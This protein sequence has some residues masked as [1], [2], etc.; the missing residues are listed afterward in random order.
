LKR[1]LKTPIEVEIMTEPKRYNEEFMEMLEKLNTI[2]IKKGEPF[3]ARAYQKAQETIMT[4]PNN[5]ISPNQLKG[6]PNIGSTIMDKLQEYVSTGTLRILESEKTNPINIL[7]DVYGIGPKKAQELV[8]S[9]ITT[10][11]ELR[12]RQNELLNDIQK[13]GLRYYEEIQERIPRSEIE[14]YGVVFKELFAKVSDPISKF[15]IVGSYRRGAQSSGDIDVIIT[16][17]TCIVYL[18]FVNELLKTGIIVELLSYGQSKTL[19]IAR[20]PGSNRIA[21]RIDFLYAP[22]NEFA[23]AILYFTGSKIFNTVMRQY[24]LNQGYTFNEHGIYKLENKK[25]GAQVSEKFATEKDIFDFLGLQYKSPDERLDGRAV[26]KKDIAFEEEVFEIVPVLRKKSKTRKNR[27][28]S[29]KNEQALPATIQPAEPAILHLIDHFKHTGI[30]TLENLNEIQLTDMIRIANQKY[31][32]QTQI[33]TDNQYD[34]VKEFMEHKYPNNAVL[35]EIGAEVEQNKVALPYEMP[36]M[37]KIKPDTNILPK[38]SATYTGP[39]VI[40]CKLDGVSGLYTT[41]GSLPKLYTRGNGKVGQ[42]ISHLIPFLRLPKTMGIVI[43]GEIIIPKQLFEQKYK[44]MFANP[45]NMVSGIVNHKHISEYITDIRFVAYEVISPELSPSAQMDYLGTINVERVLYQVTPTLSNE[46]L[47]SVLVDWRNTYTYEI[48]GIIVSDDNIYPRKSKNPEHAF[49]F[50]MVLS[51][52][53]AEAIVVDVI[54]TPSKDGYLKPRVQFEP[55]HL[56]GVTITFATGFNG[57]FIKNNNIGIGTTIE[58]IRSGDVIPY[59]KS[60]IVP[61]EEPKMPSV[62][63]K[64][65]DTH[66]DVMLEN[67]SED[68]TVKE[69]NITGFFRGIG[70]EGLS[71][72]NVT[73]IIN[74]GFTTVPDIIGMTEDDF[75]T[76][77]G[78]K[79]KLANKIYTGI[80]Q[81]LSEASIVTLMSS[82]NIFGRGFS[83]TK[84]NIVFSE[85]PNIL[86]SSATDEEKIKLV[87]S[88]KGMGA[89]SAEAFI[90]NI[91]TFKE[92]LMECGLGYK[93]EVPVKETETV[94]DATHAL[95]GKTVV[96]TGTRDKNIIEFLKIVGAKQGASVNKNTHLV[97]AKNKDDDTGKAEE[98]RK[99]GV[100]IM[101]VDD[102]IQIYL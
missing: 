29:A 46:L 86:V 28:A 101:S 14:E 69:K 79:D 16:D 57:A 66:V 93:L 60:V 84:M 45:R 23:F 35:S 40:S 4:Y 37:D 78:F 17:N 12:S 44:T 21:R 64:W 70:V 80:K 94:V 90:S 73:R 95:F 63:Y 15:E 47:S 48:D 42:D 41:Q 51:D 71:S 91:D 68:P 22:L 33:M 65:N 100:P 19:V 24:G 20:L 2:M 55:I 98:A 83:D 10:I 72:G 89:K 67:A 13:V 75:L 52:Q 31:Y 53:I 50:K 96:L 3:R 1:H 74:A 6:L 76:V 30:S 36:S 88:V 11:E 49:G 9:G 8:N 62:P 34:I 59:I 56:G 25:K 87:S 99:L 92:F 58:L 18:N 7:C 102:F 97:V 77:D 5:I 27:Q 54:W 82:S 61:S 38:W 39:Y 32:N 85:L 43:R 26:V 81:K